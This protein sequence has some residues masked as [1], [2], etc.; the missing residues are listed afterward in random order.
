MKGTALHLRCPPLFLGECVESERAPLVQVA[1]GTGLALSAQ[2]LGAH[3]RA[4]HASCFRHGALITAT[5][6]AIAATSAV[7][8]VGHSR[9]RVLA[10]VN[11]GIRQT[12]FKQIISLTA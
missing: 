9:R 1:R 4:V 8:E 5:A 7:R 3:T 11:Q 10:T 12:V 6:A 2:T